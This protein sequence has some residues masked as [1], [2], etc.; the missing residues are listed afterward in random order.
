MSVVL[1]LLLLLLLC[2]VQVFFSPMNMFFVVILFAF[3]TNVVIADEMLPE[4]V[5]QYEILPPQAYGS[6]SAMNNG[7]QSSSLSLSLSLSHA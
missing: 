5:V 1:L 4:A 2:F 3:S 6:I 7:Q